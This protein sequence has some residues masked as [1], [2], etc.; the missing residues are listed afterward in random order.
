[1]SVIDK[2]FIGT[3]SEPR[4]IVVEKGQ[5]K[6]FAKATGQANPI[7]FDEDAAHAAGHP[8]IPVPPT[9]AFSLALGAP[10][11]KGD[12]FQIITDLRK[13]LHGEQSFTYHHMLYAGDSVT[14]V[15][16]TKDIY[17]KRNGALE[18]LVQD[19]AFT[20]QHGQLCVE[21]RTVTVVR[22]S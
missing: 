1:M 18:F 7:Y 6:F 2:S 21:M 17:E 14:L 10:A 8:A 16:T 13:I 9:F 19:T 4:A 5:L 20:N 22:N 15:T 11:K 12:A 3:V